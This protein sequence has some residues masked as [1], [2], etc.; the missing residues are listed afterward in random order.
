MQ[1]CNNACNYLPRLVYPWGIQIPLREG[2]CCDLSYIYF[3]M[4]C[5]FKLPAS[6]SNL[7]S[8]W[9]GRYTFSCSAHHLLIHQPLQITCYKFSNSGQE[10]QGI[11]QRSES[12]SL[13]HFVFVGSTCHSEFPTF[14]RLVHLF[15]VGHQ[16]WQPGP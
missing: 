15:H 7:R 5:P 16:A 14:G 2:C 9:D 3:E 8:S 4:E 1:L 6:C 12:K 11:P 13:A 10:P